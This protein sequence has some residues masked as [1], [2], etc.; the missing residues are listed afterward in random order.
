MG[1]E[2][3]GKKKSWLKHFAGTL[4]GP[5]IFLLICRLPFF[6]EMNQEA[7]YV[8][9]T[10]GWFVAWVI[11]APFSWGISAMVPL[12]VLPLTGMDFMAVAGIY[13]QGNIGVQGVQTR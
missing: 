3:K 10:F 5:I 12:I 13:G 6:Q 11:A 9:A 7:V 4:S 2:D 8:L 1:K